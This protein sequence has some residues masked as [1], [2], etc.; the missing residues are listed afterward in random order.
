ML[1]R[2]LQQHLNDAFLLSDVKCHLPHAPGD[3]FPDDDKQRREQQ[4]Y[5]CQF[6]IHRH[7]HQEGTRELDG[8]DG[9]VCQLS[10][11]GIAN[12]LYILLQSGGDVAGVHIFTVIDL[13]LEQMT[14]DA[15]PDGGALYGSGAH[16]PIIVKLST[17]HPSC[18]GAKQGN[19]HQYHVGSRPRMNGGVDEAFT[20]PHHEQT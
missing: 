5:P 15:E 10:R 18:D 7:H 9:H 4:Q 12:H 16:A 3:E 1:Y 14:E 6:G 19:N 13:P 2:L 11:G 17:E 8:S 20:Q